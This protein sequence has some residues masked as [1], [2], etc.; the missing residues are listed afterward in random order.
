M[1]T[2]YLG[3]N[4]SGRSFNVVNSNGSKIGTLYHKERFTYSWEW[5]FI[6]GKDHKKIWF[7]NSSGNYVEGWL[8]NDDPVR[9]WDEFLFPNYNYGPVLHID[10]PTK[11]YNSAGQHAATAQAGDKCRL[12]NRSQTGATHKDWGLLSCWLRQ[13]ENADFTYYRDYFIDTGVGKNSG[14]TAV[15]GNWN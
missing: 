7:L 11:I 13:K 8:S 10:R 5:A 4:M 1:S 3:I 6:N 12:A 15:Y 14:N 2:S 9:N